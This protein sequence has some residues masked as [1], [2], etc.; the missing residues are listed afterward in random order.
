M[1]CGLLVALALVV[2]AVAE[3][4]AFLWSSTEQFNTHQDMH[5]KA[6]APEDVVSAVMEHSGDAVNV[7]FTA[8]LTTEKLVAAYRCGLLSSFKDSLSGATSHVEIIDVLGDVQLASPFDVVAL[9]GSSPKCSEGGKTL[10]SVDF[11][12]VNTLKVCLP[13]SESVWDS[14][15]CPEDVSPMVEGIFTIISAIKANNRDFVAALVPLDEPKDKVEELIEK[16]DQV[17]AVKEEVEKVEEV[18]EKV[19]EVEERVERVEKVAQP[20][21]VRPRRNLRSTYSSSDD[22]STTAT[23]WSTG[24]VAGGMITIVL[25]IV[26]GFG[27]SFLFSMQTQA[28]QSKLE[29]PKAKTS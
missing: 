28:E 6:F 26:L 16:V 2:V 18:V 1:K 7:F 8:P 21:F 4:P 20:Q 14:N 5:L 29:L 19:A 25:L 9:P 12:T 10:E 11:T 22:N 27:W 15:T 17:E 3:H 13:V 23:I 24:F